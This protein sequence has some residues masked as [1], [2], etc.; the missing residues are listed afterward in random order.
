M[1]GE[2][3]QNTENTEN[4]ENTVVRLRAPKNAVD[5]RAVTWWT[6]QALL[7]VGPVV[8][9]LGVLAALLPDARGWLLAGLALVVV[10]GV[11]Y[12]VIMPRWRYR[13]HRWEDTDEAVYARSGWVWQEWRV[14]PMSRIQTVDTARGPLQQ[15]FRLSTLTVT[16]ASAK[17][18]IKIDGL[19]HELAADLVVRLT[20]IAQANPGDAT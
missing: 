4:A 2:N 12:V 1:S 13:V 5:R 3:T 11:P 17:G 10:L 20:A 16:T 6:V 8:V 7:E 19:D 9:V 14:A 15:Y 18:A